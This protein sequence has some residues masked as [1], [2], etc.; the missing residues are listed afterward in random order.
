MQ[1]VKLWLSLVL[2][3]GCVCPSM[4]HAQIDPVKRDLIQLGYNGALEG[5]APLAAYAFYYRNQPGL[6]DNTNLTL[7]T[8]I[9]PVYLDSE[10]GI[11]HVLGPETD[12][13]IGLAGGGYADSYDEIDRGTF[14]QA[15][16]FVGHS[17]EGS[18][19]VYHLF[20]D[21]ALVP[22]WGQIRGTMHYSFYERDDTAPTFRLPK[23]MGTYT[24]RAGLR[25]GGKEPLLFPSLAMEL[26][27]WYEGQ[28][29]SEN[30]SYGYTTV[31]PEGDRKVNTFSQL[32]WGQAL[33]AYTLPELK[34]TFFVN[35]T[36]GGSESADR[37]SAYRL[38]SLLPFSSEFPLSLPGYYYQELS[39]V[40]Y[41]LMGGNYLLPLDSKRHWNLTVNAATAWVDYLPGLDQ[42]GH[43]NS[44]VGGGILYRSSSLKVMVGYA[45]GID[46][47]RDGNRG[48]NSIGVLLQLDLE[49]AKGEMF[50][51]TD[52]GLWRGLQ[53]VFGNLSE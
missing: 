43:W 40:H 42:P 22:L 7:R 31:N 33:L 24:V 3:S 14:S 39:A 23:D 27:A 21:G 16:S 4:L 51:S 13:G 50:N 18:L 47:I 1:S 53:H 10:L 41:V 2:V 48:A 8:A 26:S 28:F 45:R 25:W 30:D 29:R 37:F 49:K 52:P 6:F 44:G 12:I 32:F 19:S 35:V 38:G 5:H 36:A 9:A 11:S 15:Q 20:N 17:G 46:A 34:H